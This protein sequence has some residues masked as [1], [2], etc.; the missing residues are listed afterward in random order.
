MINSTSGKKS[1]HDHFSLKSGSVEPE[2]E[3]G[4]WE[5]DMLWNNL[6][7]RKGEQEKQDGRGRGESR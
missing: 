7:S 6:S 5:G 3:M 4:I 1:P 2:P